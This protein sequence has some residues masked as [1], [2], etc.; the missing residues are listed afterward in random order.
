M[1]VLIFVKAKHRMALE[2]SLYPVSI[3]PLAQLPSRR[4]A[5]GISIEL[6]FFRS[7]VDFRK[8]SFDLCIFLCDFGVRAQ[9]ASK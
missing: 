8:F 9:I 5:F 2:S 1:P 7:G 6:H 3:D 4:M